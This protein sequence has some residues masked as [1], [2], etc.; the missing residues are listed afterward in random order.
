MNGSTI[1]DKSASWQQALNIDLTT[2]QFIHCHQEPKKTSA[3]AEPEAA[4][5]AAAGGPDAD[6]HDCTVVLVSVDG[7]QHQPLQFPAGGQFILFCFAEPFLAHLL[8]HLFGE[9]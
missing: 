5:A 2:V 7:T 4:E 8:G 3:A 6:G 1:E 9:F